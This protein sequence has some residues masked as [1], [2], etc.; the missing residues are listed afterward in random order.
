VKNF[1]SNKVRV[2]KKYIA[3]S[4]GLLGLEQSIMERRAGYFTP[5]SILIVIS[6]FRDIFCVVPPFLEELDGK[7]EGEGEEDGFDKDF[8]LSN[9]FFSDNTTVGNTGLQASGETVRLIN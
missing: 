2:F 5:R 4:L 7:L 6:L 3:S 9:D 1:I 8:P